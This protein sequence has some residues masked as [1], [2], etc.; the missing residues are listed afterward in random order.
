MLCDAHIH[1]FSPSFFAALARQR[2]VA[3]ADALRHLGWDDPESVDAL[4]DRWVSELD[5]N[6]VARAAIIG[7]LPGEED[8]V[9]SA[10]ERHPGRLVGYAML[11]PTSADA[12]SR[13]MTAL[14]RGLRGVCLF[15]AMHRYSLHD[16]SVGRVA[17]M[18]AAFRPASPPL[19]FVHCGVL[20]V[21][22]R[23]KLGLPSPFD[24]S[25][26]NPLYLHTLA[27]R[28]PTLPIV[29]PHFGAGLFREALMLADL[30][31]NV[32]VDTSSS[33]SWIRYTPGLTLEQ[34]FSTALDVLG[35]SRLLFGSD[36]SFFPRGW[37]REVYDRQKAA[38]ASI[39]ATAEVR[40][41]IFGG[42]F[43]RLTRP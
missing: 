32:H 21:G 15:P 20:S 28:F 2:Q 11:D 33:N 23:K 14:E 37:N 42:N 24:V 19:L 43:E 12:E 9:A 17:E 35:P 6:E 34:V 41:Q 8:V 30:A 26:G 3:T 16:A 38:L 36:S 18:L 40:E 13:V 27:G 1:F 29:I 39:G 10:I 22:V 4:A 5:R 7:S 25:L 31:P